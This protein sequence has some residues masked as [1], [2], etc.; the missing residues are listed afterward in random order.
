MSK[1]LARLLACVLLPLS[2]QAQTLDHIKQSGSFTIAFRESSVP[3]S[4]VVKG[5]PEPL[6]LAVDLCKKIAQAVKAELKLPALKINYVPVTSATRIPTIQQG[7]ADIECGS[8]TDNRERREQVSF[9]HHHFFAAVQM[10]TK[11]GGPVRDWS[12]LE[13]RTVVFTQGTSTK[14]AVE[15]NARTKVLKY[16]VLEGQDHKDSFSLLA[17]GQADA[18]VL[19]D[20]LLAGLRAAS[21]KPKDYELAGSRLTI[22][23]YALMIRKGDARFL[24]LVD[25]E[26]ERLFFS[27]EYAKL[28][29]RWFMQPIPP[30]DLTL[31]L[32]P[33]SL[34]RSQ[35][36]RPQSVIPD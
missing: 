30:N 32:P 27:G 31:N 10:L 17:S 14:A 2:A 18:F 36:R 29:E 34:L 13:G 21:I 25:R 3:F 4:Y 16:K 5:T 20:V 28:Y 9:S 19:E 24:K 6:G 33:S 7:A 11:T 35:M 22:E 26:L 1:T 23:P 8:T 12:D 15:K